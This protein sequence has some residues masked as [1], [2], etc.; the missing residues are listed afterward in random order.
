[1]GV[2]DDWETVESWL[3]SETLPAMP[4]DTVLPA[5]EKKF[6]E[7]PTLSNYRI[8]PPEDFWENFPKDT[9]L[10]EKV[11]AKLDT[12][13]FS[14]LI[15]SHKPYLTASQVKRADK[16]LSD[17]EGGAEAYQKSVLPELSTLNTSS[18]YEWGELLTDKIAS[19]VKEGY[20]K[21]PFDSPP[22]PGFRVNP[23][24]AIYRNEKVR[25]VINMSAPKGKSFNENVDQVKLEKVWMDTAKSFSYKLKEVGGSALMSKFDIKDAY[26]TIPAKKED[27]RLQGFQWLGKFFFETQMIFGAVPSV[28]NFDRL[29]NT[30]VEMAVQDSKIPRNLVMR[31]LDDIPVVGKEKDKVTERFSTS[32]QQACDHIGLRLAKDCPNNDK[33]FRNQKFG[34]VL[35]IGFN[36]DSLEWWIPEEKADR[37]TRVGLKALTSKCLNLEECQVLMGTMNDIGQLCPFLRQFLWSGNRFITDIGI[38]GPA[39]LPE[40]AKA[41]LGICLRIIQSARKGLPIASRPINPPLEALSFYSDAAGDSFVI[42]NGNRV[43]NSLPGDRGVACLLWDQG[44]R[45]SWWTQLTWPESFLKDAVDSK[46]AK[47]GSKSTTLECIGILLPFVSSP[48]LVKGKQVV[49]NVDNMAVI[50]G[51]ENNGVK[52]DTTATIILRTVRLAAAYLGTIVHIQHVPRVSNKPAELADMLSRKNS[53]TRETWSWVGGARRSWVRGP[54]TEWLKDPVED[55]ELPLKVLDC[56]K[57]KI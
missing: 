54:L 13:K 34:I 3:R 4:K 40:Q 2:P 45:V 50:F 8:D 18:A 36:A 31:T 22:F 46:G 26:K 1:L 20:V 41:D 38:Y 10:P 55:W 17:M 39:E 48:E 7:I 51:W 21:G 27:W 15:E 19:W 49:F 35:G 24:M 11:S 25:P 47:F 12:R 37:A 57:S 44:Y 33:A 56:I 32:L 16:V 29:G 6:P 23:L 53:T 42:V 14:E 43:S 5:L 52:F 9:V 28:C 30:M